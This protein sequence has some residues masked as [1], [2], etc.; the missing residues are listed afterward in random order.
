MYREIENKKG[1]SF[2]SAAQNLSE[3][4]RE[5]RRDMCACVSKFGKGGLRAVVISHLYSSFY[6]CVQGL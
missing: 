6:A 1:A 5:E 3:R 4:G 2:A